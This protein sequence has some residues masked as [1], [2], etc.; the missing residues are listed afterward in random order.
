MTE[1]A[2]GTCVE[3]ELASFPANWVQAA[4]EEISEI[5]PT[6]DLSKVNDDMEVTFLPMK[7]VEE[8]TGRFDGSCV[9]KLREVRKGHTS[10]KNGD[11]LFA[12]ITPCM[13]NGKIAIVENLQNGIGFGSTEFHVIRLHESLPRKLFFFF[14]VQEDLRKT[15]QRS[16][17]GTAGQLRVPLSH[18]KQIRIPFPPLTEQFRIV[19]K[20]EELF[21]KLDAG[22]KCLETVE[23][24]LKRYQQLVLKSAFDGKLTEEWRRTHQ[25]ELEPSSK[26]LERI[27]EERTRTKRH[28]E[29]P[30]LNASNLPDL[31]EG[32]ASTRIGEVFDVSSG[33]T[34]R[35]DTPE[36]WNGGISWVSSGEVAFR[37]IRT[38]KEHI[39]QLGLDKSSAK[40]YPPGTV[41]LALY[42]EGKTRGQVAILRIHAATNQAVAAILCSE[43]PIS[44]EYVYWWLYYRYHQTRLIRGGANQPNMYLHNVRVMPIP[45][46]SFAEQQRIADEIERRFSIAEG[47]EETVI[48]S[49]RQAERLRQSV[50]KRAFEGQLVSQDPNDEPA[51]VLLERIKSLK[52]QMI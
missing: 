13:E 11:L 33:G 22:V 47:V 49:S 36:Y 40:I 35:R 27:K 7:A 52:A 30:T 17:T 20:V 24:Q 14:L 8:M 23:A 39:T 37:E 38:T 18:M 50:L 6:L 31:P 10:F 43:S 41:L 1:N 21:T 12:K 29:H 26:L 2:N 3:G 45:L 16:M 51:S 48:S 25:E 44:P 28:K 42:G 15:A 9:R 34:P 4:L 19:A 46:A 5:N 32:W